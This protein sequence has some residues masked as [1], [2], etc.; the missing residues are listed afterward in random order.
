MI[1]MSL[2][3][4]SFVR[5]INH[6]LISRGLVSYPNKE[7]ADEA[8]D[9][10]ADAAPAE[11][12][13]AIP[14]VSPEAGPPPNDI[15]AIANKLMEIAA[16]LMAQAGGGAGAPPPMGGDGMPPPPPGGEMPPGGG[17]GMPPEIAKAASEL[18][19]TAAAADLETLASEV[20]VECMDKAAAETKLATGTGTL[21]VGGTQ[22]NTPE[23]AAK[24]DAVGALDLKNRPAGAYQTGVGQTDLKTEPGAI[25]HLGAPTVH[26]A[27]SPAGTNSV[28]EG[29]KS[30]SVQEELR[31]IANKLV[32]LHDGK[33]SNTLA[34]AAAH[35]PVAKLDLK[36]RGKEKYH[37][38]QGKTNIGEAAAARIGLEQKHP[39]APANTPAGTNSVIQASKT[40]EEDAFITLFKKC[41][42]DVGQYLP[43]TL[44]DDEKVASISRMV[45]FSHD[46]RQAHILELHAKTAAVVPAVKVAGGD[47]SSIMRDIKGKEGYKTKEKDGEKKSA[48]LDR[49][50]EI[51]AASSAPSAA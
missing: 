20:A 4:R 5:G 2:F 34:Q 19:K 35:D 42:E 29:T 13:G 41:A 30:G 22:Q 3:K 21:V 28:T 11:G 15:A 10:V 1:T 9:A 18:Q 37:V 8:A 32:G 45:G 47:L 24:N 46:E 36:N 26:P 38:G 25:G 27:N 17:G 49:I 51:A 14:E 50:Y 16:A 12:P 44:S 7:A 33:D 39:E 6:T 23:A 48:L 43:A 31:K 40:S